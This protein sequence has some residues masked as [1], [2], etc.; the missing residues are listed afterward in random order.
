MTGDA[1]EL[2]RALDFL[3]V[4]VP[5]SCRHFAPSRQT[6]RIEKRAEKQFNAWLGK[7]QGPGWSIT[8]RRVV[9]EVKTMEQMVKG[10]AA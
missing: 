3:K 2:A 7:M 8:R 9:R 4:M 10:K 5:K 6:W 1:Q